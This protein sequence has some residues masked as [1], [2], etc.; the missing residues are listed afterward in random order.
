MAAVR[1]NAVTLGVAT[2]IE[3]RRRGQRVVRVHQF[4]PGVKLMA[5]SDGRVLIVKGNKMR[6]ERR[7]IRG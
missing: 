2:R 1:I 6:V 5:T 3:Y 4:G 7:E